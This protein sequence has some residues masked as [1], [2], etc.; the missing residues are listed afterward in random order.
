MPHEDWRRGAHLPYLNLEPTERWISYVSLWDCDAWPMRPKPAP[1]QLWAVTALLL[2]PNYT[3]LVLYGDRHVVYK[4]LAHQPVRE[5]A[6]S[7]GCKNEDAGMFICLGWDADLHMAPPSWCHC[8]SLSL[9]PVNPHW[10]YL[11]GFTFLV[12]AHP[13]SPRQNPK[14]R[15]TVVVEQ[16]Q[17][18]QQQ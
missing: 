15:K 10:F 9:A 3:A 1:F 13:G 11:P 4:Q 5:T 18:Q 14:S 17:Q 7:R 6:G 12:S 8:H 2:V 16:Q